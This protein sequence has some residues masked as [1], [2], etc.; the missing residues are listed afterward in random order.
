[1]KPE[2]TKDTNLELIRTIEDPLLLEELKVGPVQVTSLEKL[3]ENYIRFKSSLPSVTLHYA[4]KANPRP[5]VLATLASMGSNFDVASIQEIEALLELGIAPERMIYSNTSKS[6]LDIAF[7]HK[8]GIKK[9]VSHSN[10][11]LENLA[12]R[13]P[14]SEVI[15]RISADCGDNVVFP[16]KGRFG[17]GSVAETEKLFA[18]AAE[19]GLKPSGIHAHHGSENKDPKV[20]DETIATMAQIMRRNREKYPT[21]KIMDI[22]GGYASPNSITSP[23]PEEYGAVIEASLARHA[24][25]LT[26]LE[27]IAEPG[28]VI[29]ST[30]SVTFAEVLETKQNNM[31]GSLNVT[32]NAG[33]KN[34]G[35]QEPGVTTLFARRN[36]KGN[37]EIINV[38]ISATSADGTEIPAE[39]LVMANYYDSTCD[40]FKAMVEEPFAPATLKKGD[41]V[42]FCG[43]GAY[44]N[45]LQQ[46]EFNKQIGPL[47][48]V[49]KKCDGTSELLLQEGQSQLNLR[50]RRRLHGVKDELGIGTGL[51]YLEYEEAK[52]IAALSDATDI[53]SPEAAKAMMEKLVKEQRAKL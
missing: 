31:D 5:D 38:P 27:V 47:E 25:D 36:P 9:F 18:K 37:L 46:T 43:T 20:W 40:D 30:I 34:A 52:K 4:V 50:N 44:C 10:D 16:H 23:T 45:T 15:I 13:A 42:I 6:E 3:A 26:D 24:S 19:L 28:R 53:P 11:D 14:G 51:S 48:L 29:A 49:L 12:A 32:T 7:A 39:V 35:L 22:S 1:M 41:I 21:L 8:V 33:A 17:S 2:S